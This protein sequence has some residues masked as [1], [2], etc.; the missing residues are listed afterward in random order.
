MGSEG[1]AWVYPVTRWWPRECIL[2]P[3]NRC[4]FTCNLG[5]N[6][7]LIAIQGHWR[8]NIILSKIDNGGLLLKLLPDWKWNSSADFHIILLHRPTSLYCVV[9]FLLCFIFYKLKVCGDAASSKS[10]KTIF[11]TAFA[12]FMS[13]FAN[14]CTVSS[15]FIII[16]FVTAI[17]DQ[18]LQ[19]LKA[20]VTLSIF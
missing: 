16:L 15:F 11:P 18:R 7:C 6:S 2:A 8:P 17:C 19:L 1:L 9:F 14:S 12:P 5:L 4:P 20:Q 10:T 3:L 13:H